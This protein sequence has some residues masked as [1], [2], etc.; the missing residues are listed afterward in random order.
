MPPHAVED[1]E[2]SETFG[3]FEPII[4]RDGVPRDGRRFSQFL[5]RNAQ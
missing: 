3:E 2:L 5:G 1:N 4:A